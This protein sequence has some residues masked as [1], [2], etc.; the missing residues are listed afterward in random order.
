MLVFPGDILGTSRCEYWY[1]EVGPK[2]AQ[3][4]HSRKLMYNILAALWPTHKYGAVPSLDEVMSLLSGPEQ[5]G[6]YSQCVTDSKDNSTAIYNALAMAGGRAS[7]PNQV[8]SIVHTVMHNYPITGMTSN[9]VQASRALAD[10]LQHNFWCTDCRGVFAVGVLNEFGFPPQTNDPYAHAK[11]WWQGHNTASEH[12]AS[13]R[14]GHPWLFPHG[15][16]A[17]AMVGGGNLFYM[18]YEDS[19]QMWTLPE[20]FEDLI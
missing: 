7:Q 6:D 15:D 13:T 9:Q 20:S 14:G 10:F 1:P 12:T 11:W 18:S 2:S 16:E 8:W 17:I 3:A 19:E 4:A 5:I